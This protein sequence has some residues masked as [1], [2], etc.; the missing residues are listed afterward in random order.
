M[1]DRLYDPLTALF[2][3]HFKVPPAQVTPL[4]ISGSDR[5]YFRL[6]AGE[7]KTAIGTLSDHVAENNTFFY[8]TELFRKHGVRVPEV[9]GVSRDRKA[10]LQEDFG[11]ESLFGKLQREGLSEAVRAHYHKA[12][13]GLARIQWLAGREADF[14]QCFATST[15]DEPAIL[16]DLHY[17]KYYFADLQKVS[18]DRQAVAEEMS[19]MA[20]EL[21]RYQPQMLMYRD[22]QS[23]NIM[24]L[25]GGEVGFIDY[26]GA[27]QGPPQYD[28][29]SLLWQAKA[30]LPQDWRDD[31]INGYMR[32]VQDLKIRF[33]EVHFRR[34]YTQFVLL[35]LLQVL[36]AYGFRGLLERKPHFLS[37]IAPAL[38]NLNAFLNDNPQAVPYPA[39]RS[40]L[41]RLTESDVIGRY[42][43]DAHPDQKPKLQVVIQSFSYKVGL[44]A[45][46]SGNGGGYVFDCRG[47]LNPGRQA[48]YKHR[49][50]R[51][52]GVK[53]Y[54]ETQTKMSQFL[55]NV[56]ALVSLSVEDYL[57]RGFENLMVSF[58][59]TGGQH[60]SVYAAE[61][62]AQYLKAR[63][64]MDAVAVHLNEGAWPA[65]PAA[66][67]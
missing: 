67:D 42:A 26:Q 6:S 13:E 4:E 33:D 59:C 65:A 55:Q 29:A 41:E 53:H 34:G 10:Y 43:F 17:F 37:S 63:Y 56:F 32:A 64:G 7:K 52:A 15:F 9:Y 66:E 31:L 40:L 62:L 21:G 46:E 2:E 54:L 48:E 8:F 60:R 20:R 35:R 5:H 3:D 24:V 12:L 47:V 11:G 51:D 45:D 1:T 28:L 57:E 49:S 50:G 44:P 36:G 39:L 18:Y 25:P 14:K 16:A 27:M 30:G 22:F 61:A 23:R 58:G 19:Q 38:R